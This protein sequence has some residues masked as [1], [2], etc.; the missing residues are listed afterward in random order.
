[1]KYSLMKEHI[2]PQQCEKIEYLD[3]KFR[4]LWDCTFT[5]LLKLREN[6]DNWVR[7]L[8]QVLQFFI[9]VRRV[10]V[11]VII[12]QRELIAFNR[13]HMCNKEYNNTRHSERGKKTRQ[14]KE[15]V[16]RQ[17]QGM[18]RPGL[19]E[20]PRGQWRTGK[21]GEDWLQNHLRCP[22]DPCS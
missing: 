17:H 22:N 1:M 21:N 20:G 9:K 8:S 3:K 15:E 5:S 12:L 18:D 19:L 2:K 4:G 7:C 16:G 11:C 6:T 13:D 10:T 14:T